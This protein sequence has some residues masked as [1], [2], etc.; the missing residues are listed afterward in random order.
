MRRVLMVGIVLA[1]VAGLLS[2]CALSAVRGGPVPKDRLSDGVYRGS[3]RNGPVSAVVEIV[4]EDQ[5][6]REIELVTHRTWWGGAAEEA[7]PR[8]IIEQQSTSVDAVSGATISSTAI[9]N[10]V[11]D[12]VEKATN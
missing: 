7:I 10:A 8:S 9:M 4:V 6:I 3:A 1:L 5:A 12:A 11:Q 2:S